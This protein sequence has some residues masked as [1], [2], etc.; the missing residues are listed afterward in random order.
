MP[1]A[2]HC[3]ASPVAAAE[4]GGSR[5][6]A[7]RRIATFSRESARAGARSPQAPQRRGRQHRREFAAEDAERMRLG[8]DG[9]GVHR[10]AHR[11]AQRAHPER[12]QQ[13]GQ[14]DDEER[15]LP[16]G[17]PERR[18]R[19]RE[20]RVPAADD[21][22]ADR[23]AEARAEIDAARVE[24][25]HRRAARG[26]EVVREQ[27]ERGG[28]RAGF[29]D[30]D[31]DARRGEF[32]EV[33]RESRYRRRRAPERQRHRDQRA[34]RP[35]VGEL[36]ERNPEERVEDRERGAEQES[37]LGIAEAEIA[38]DLL[39]Q[40]REDLAVD[41][42]E[43]VDEDEDAEHVVRVASLATASPAASP[44]PALTTIFR[45]SQSIR[46]AFSSSGFSCCV[47]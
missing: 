47:Q 5:V 26:G 27:R 35:H 20:R 18:G 32:A 9:Q 7:A 45:R 2:I 22:S 46:I 29:A 34:T 24:R 12:E 6:R 39:V 33:A 31:G 37:H 28:R 21:L 25:E 38:L 44:P 13:A 4:S 40:D 41:E 11:L 15:D 1:S 43:H 3:F 16:A 14:A 42:V 8:R 36:A 17:E 19:V 23:E 30:A 10:A